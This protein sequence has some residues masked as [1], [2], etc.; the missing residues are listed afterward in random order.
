MLRAIS[1]STGTFTNTKNLFV[2]IPNLGLL[3]FPSSS[4]TL[5]SAQGALEGSLEDLRG[6]FLSPSVNINNKYDASGNVEANM[7]ASGKYDDGS[8]NLK[9]D[10]VS[11]TL[12]PIHADIPTTPAWYT[13]PVNKSWKNGTATQTAATT[14]TNNLGYDVIIIGVDS[15][16][17]DFASYTIGGTTYYPTGNISYDNA[18]YV[19]NGA[20]VNFGGASPNVSAILYWYL[21]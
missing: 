3:V 19:P 13:A 15:S 18:F 14:W 11:Q 1:L 10:V 7:E 2:L 16:G 21:G 6:F 20:T 9:A 12:N 8:G 4:V 17:A 5:N